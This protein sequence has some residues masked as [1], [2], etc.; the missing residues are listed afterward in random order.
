MRRGSLDVYDEERVAVISQNLAAVID[1]AAFGECTW[2][3]VPAI[4]SEAFP[5]SWG[6]LANMN[7]PDSRLFCRCRTWIRPS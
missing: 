7:F 1:A 3:R 6:G 2:D 4:L 5:G